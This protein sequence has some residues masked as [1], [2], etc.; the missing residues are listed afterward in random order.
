MFLV[1]YGCTPWK[2]NG[3]NL[4]ITH[5]ERKRI[6]QTSMT[7]GSMLIFQG[8]I[9]GKHLLQ[10]LHRQLPSLTLS[11]KIYMSTGPKGILSKKKCCVMYCYICIS[12]YL[13]IYIYT[14]PYIIIYIA[15]I[16]LQY[17]YDNYMYH[18]RFMYRSSWMDV[19]V[20]TCMK[21]T[22]TILIYV[23]SNIYIYSHS[24]KIILHPIYAFIDA[25]TFIYVILCWRISP[26]RI[27]TCPPFGPILG[28]LRFFPSPI[29][30][31]ARL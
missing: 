20:C 30:R 18:F 2:I 14:Y 6:F 7:L 28:F 9:F 13:Y 12:Q 29:Y 31:Q 8:V 15:F 27:T 23:Y 5:L 16:L 1:Q 26:C 11:K 24:Y 22:Y 10:H 4:Q 25:F 21:Y 3:W 17:Q 19:C